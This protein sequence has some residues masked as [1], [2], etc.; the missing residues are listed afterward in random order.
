MRL[1]VSYSCIRSCA[2]IMYVVGHPCLFERRVFIRSPT[3]TADVAGNYT[4]NLVVNDGIED[5]DSGTV[6]IIAAQ[7]QTN[8]NAERSLYILDDTCSARRKGHAQ[9]LTG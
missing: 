5:S 3:F 1:N 2:V 7:W 6:Y 4:F 8:P 9:G